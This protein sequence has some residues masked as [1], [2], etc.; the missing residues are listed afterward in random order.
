MVLRDTTGESESGI[1]L[2]GLGGL[3]EGSNGTGGT[4]LT[5]ARLWRSRLLRDRLVRPAGLVPRRVLEPLHDR[6]HGRVTAAGTARG[7]GGS[8]SGISGCPRGVRLLGCGLAAAGWEP[9]FRGDPGL[10]GSA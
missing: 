9:V 5:D 8:W 4:R 10:P 3:E 7:R 2:S 6:H 1:G